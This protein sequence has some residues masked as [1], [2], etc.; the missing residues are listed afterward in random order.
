MGRTPWTREG[1]LHDVDNVST[2]AADALRDG[3]ALY[4][5]GA[6]LWDR[7]VWDDYHAELVEICL[8][9]GLRYDS[10]KSSLSF[11]TFAGEILRKRVVDRFR[12]HLGDTRYRRE[13]TKRPPRGEGAYFTDE[14]GTA[15]DAPASHDWVK[16]VIDGLAIAV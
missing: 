8:L 9:L 10:S 12:K 6:T 4:G 13:P 5:G 1:G 16:E 2:F 7:A 3:L 15:F 14:E 11:S